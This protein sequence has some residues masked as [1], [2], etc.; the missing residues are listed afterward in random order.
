MLQRSVIVMS[1]KK[2]GVSL[3]YS[4]LIDAMHK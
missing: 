2:Y 1:A 3:D 4:E